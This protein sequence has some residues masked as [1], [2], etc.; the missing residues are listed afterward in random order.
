[1][2]PEK[3]GRQILKTEK[4]NPKKLPN[5]L[6]IIQADK[7]TT[8][9]AMAKV[10]VFWALLVASLSPLAVRNWKPPTRS[11]TKAAKPALVKAKDITLVKTEAKSPIVGTISVA[12]N[13]FDD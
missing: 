7:A 13:R 11:I 2:E 12:S 4:S 6:R 9:P 1:M 5:K 8:R 3:P 10:S